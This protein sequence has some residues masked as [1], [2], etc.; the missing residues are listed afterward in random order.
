MF[1]VHLVGLGRWGLPLL[2][3]V[4]P[5]QRPA[6][7]GGF[8]KIIVFTSFILLLSKEDPPSLQGRGGQK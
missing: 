4:F 2:I 6:G 1:S 8:M 3:W 5:S 7:W